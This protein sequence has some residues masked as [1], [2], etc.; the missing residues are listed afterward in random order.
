MIHF[1]NNVKIFFPKRIIVWVLL[2][3][4]FEYIQADCGNI[5]T[6]FSPSQTLICGPGATTLNFT[7]ASTGTGAAGAN[8]SWYLNGT[9]FDNTSGLTVPNSSTISA[10]G[11]YNYMLIAFDPSVPCRDTNIVQVIIRPLPNASF[12]FTPNNQCA[13]TTIAFT[14][15]STGTG[16]FT[17][18]TWN[19]G[20][21]TPN[22]T[23]VSPT[24][25]YAAGGSYNV[26]L[27]ISNGA[28][29]TSSFN[30]TVTVLPRPVASISGD[31]GDGDTQYCLSPVDTTSIETV[32]F[33][34]FTTGAVSYSWN[35]GDGSPVFNTVSTASI[36]HTYSNY[37]TYTV[38]MTATGA[39]GC[40]TTTT[41]TVV[42]DKFV[43]ASFSV[44]L[45]QFSGCAPHVVQPV[46]AS[47]NADQYVWNFGDGTPS[48]TTTSYTPPP[49][50]YTVGGSY[51]ISVVASNS[52][53]SSTSTVGPI[54]VVGAP[55][56][57]FTATPALGC[58][59][60]TVT[61]GNTTTGASPVNNYY[62]DFGNGNTLNGVRFP[63]PQVYYQGT[64]TIMM[65]AGNACGT[66]T[67]FRTIVVDTIPTAMIAV[68]PLEGC[69]PL[70]VTTTNNSTGGNLT[71]QWYID[72]ILTYTTQNIPNQTFTAPAGNS[73]VN[74]TI[75]LRVS[76]H[77]GFDDTTVAVI[78]HPLVVA[79][80]TP[81]S[82]TICAGSSVTFT[83]S[84]LGD[85]LTY[86]W[87]FGNGN[88]STS[89]TA[90]AQTYT[91]P[92]TYTVLLTVT[93]YC[94]TDTASAIV[95]VN[96]IPV[97]PTAPG[98]IICAG[99]TVTLNA[100]APGGT[101]QWYNAP[102]GGTL[103]QT[104]SSY[105]TPVLTTTTSY[106]VQTTA[107]GCT[108]PRTIVTV[109]VNP[110]PVAPTALGTTICAGSTATLTATAPGGTY[111]WYN[112][113]SGGTLLNTGA[114]YTTPPLLT[115]TTYYVQT[116][117]AGCAGPRTAVTVTVNP[118]PASPTVAPGVICAG[119]STTLTATAPGGT[120]QWY[121]SLSGGTLLNTGSSFT[122]PVL[123]SSTTYYVQTTVAG[124][125]SPRV[126]VNV[127]VNPY[128]VADIIPDVNAGCQGLVVNFNNN[129]TLGGS[130][131]WTFSGATPSSSVLYSPPPVTFNASGNNMVYLVVTVA[132]CTTNDTAYINIAPLPLPAF[133]LSP[134]A[135]CSPVTSTFTNTSGITAGDTYF[136]NFGNGSTS[137]L[138]NPPSMTYTATV[139]DSIYNVQL[140]IT[141]ANG[142]SDSVMH[143]VTVHANPVASFSPNNDTVCANTGIVF[144][145]NS[146]GATSYSWNFGDGGVSTTTNTSHTYP[147]PSNYIVQLIASSAFG[148]VDTTQHLVVVD[149][150]P[151][152]SFTNTTECLGFA[153]QF[154]NTSQGSIVSW[155]WNFGDGS[156]LDNSINPSHAYA[157]NGTYTVTLTVINA[158]G[159]S[160]TISHNVIVNAVPVAAFSSNTACFGQ[161]TNFTDLTSGTPISWE[162][163]F[164][165]GSPVNNLQN[166]SHTYASAG[167]YTVTLISF[168]GS[169]CSDTLS[170]TITV[171]P[172]PSA[173][174]SSANVCTNDTMI[175]SSTSVG[176]PDMFVWN[177][178]DGFFDNTNN[179]SS[180]HVYTLAGTYNVVLTVGYVST[181][182]TNSITIPVTSY[183]LT[184]PSFTSTT[185]CLNVNTIFTDATSNA[186]TQWTWNFGDGSPFDNTQN[187]SHVYSA[188][189]TYQVTLVTQNMFGCRDSITTNTVVNPLPLAQF[190]F[191]TVC[192]N[193]A[194]TY[195]DQSISAVAWSW[196]FGDGATSTNNSPTHV[197]ASNGTYNVSLIVSNLF[198]CTDTI[199]HSI[200]VNP[201]PVSDFT[202]TTACHTYPTVFTDNSTAA[203]AWVWD[204]G[205]ASG[206]DT[207]QFP[208]YTYTNPG[209]YNVSL[210]VT[211]IFGCTNTSSQT[212][213]VLPQPVADFNYSIA[214][215]RQAVNFTDVTTVSVPVSWSW[216]FGDGSP[217]DN[218]QNPSHTY[219]LGGTYNVT[220]IVSNVAGCNDTIVQSVIVNTV[221]TP[222]FSANV[223]CQGTIT[224]FNDLS[225][226]VVAITNWYYDFADGNSSFSQNPN[227]IYAAA[228]TYNVSLTVTNVNGCDSTVVMPV[229]VNVFPTA[230]YMVD[231]VCVG[232]PTTFTDTSTGSPNQWTWNFGDGNSGSTG[233]SITHV[234]A[235]AGSY[236]TSLTVSSGAGC[237]D[238]AFQIVVVR[239]DVQAGITANN[240]IC[241]DNILTLSDNS[242]V[243][244]GTILSQT[245]DF[246][247]GTPVS[248]A[249]NTTHLYPTPGTY[250]IT[251]VVV[252]DGGCSS[253]AYD[254][255]V[256]NP[257]PV[258]NFSANNT[259]EDQ[260][261]LFNDLSSGS[262]TSWNWDFG[263]GGTDT[264]QNPAY[265]YG[266][267]G[268]FNATLIVT[269][270]A[271]CADTAMRPVT[272]YS[273]PIASFT[274]NLVCW[275]DTTSFVNTSVSADGT[276]TNA[277]WDFGDGTVSSVYDPEHVL[278]GQT[279]T[280]NVTLAVIT[281]Y[282]CV[283]TLV[284]VVNTHPL[285]VFNFAPQQTSGCE[286]FTTTFTDNSTVAGGT[287]VNWLWDFG[288]GNLTYTQNPTHTYDEDGS[289]FVSLTVTSSYGC[290]MSDTLNFPVVVY[291]TPVAEFTS[292][293]NNVSVYEPNIQF[294][295]ASTGATMWDW[296]FGDNETSILQ[297][298]YHTYPDTGIYMVTLVAINQYG[299]KDTVQHPMEV[300][301][302]W[303]VFI[304]NAFTPNS[305][306]LNDVFAPKLYGIIEYKM[307]IFDRWGNEIFQTQDMDEGWNGRYKGVGAIVQQDVYVYKIVV[308]DLLFNEHQYIGSVT[309]VR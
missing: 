295:D 21:G 82:S 155:S 187:P 265:T 208:S 16:A 294:N 243:T 101:Y 112:A 190:T 131:S 140:L 214:C 284:Q 267:N 94:G 128:P 307:Y 273:Q 250:V 70:T 57:N 204:F 264:L 205:D 172:V 285:P 29:C 203:V 177:F 298:P 218:T 4:S 129:S 254:T 142:C 95:V 174:F 241:E 188:A 98:T 124:C 102:T 51:T 12:T 211:N 210:L 271:G 13:G 304:P 255:V 20:D 115:T 119:G 308:K 196:D 292:S 52:C 171:N 224:S 201:N 64:W 226:D 223:S 97:A 149:S 56:P 87:N 161:A 3:F 242:V 251:H 34:N 110:A 167:T 88:T 262:I 68:N 73:P 86:S 170:N 35:F 150:V 222:L 143:M 48:I 166:P 286:E 78:V 246:G 272:I 43:S 305:N 76:N 231:T 91:T 240:T 127:T 8:Y 77:C 81:V 37:G 179:D 233:P 17:T 61:F 270:T 225:S 168:G 136:W 239:S 289:Y 138:Q 30:T 263:D 186:P 75:R 280:Y 6:S 281:N 123:S 106:Y 60:Q 116:T 32:T 256:V 288:D 62:W 274:S 185:P 132:G 10:V 249:L 105:T 63:P 287:I 85:Q 252:S 269:T 147:I 47:Q 165:D 209:N 22:S 253:T 69:T 9:L 39:N 197:Y 153:T 121:D 120:Y 245:W 125:T 193:S 160:N 141:A 216:D 169:G 228:G 215:A 258:A 277:W 114:S 200:I 111:E 202:A 36:P 59:P 80:V 23:T 173:N 300:H 41:L 217:L 157:S 261:S 290:T 33:Y 134:A 206:M 50:T 122:T 103:L 247:D 159:C 71:Y 163:D 244:V 278:A 276:I 58:S 268:V 135:G 191:D 212:I 117:V 72:G 293:S 236:L 195:I 2:L 199:S 11:T 1:I 133:S 151:V 14:N 282:G 93:G 194:T 309:V 109:T 229:T 279:D 130:Y 184:V 84:S 15:T 118:I 28:G 260:A 303:S 156:P 5:V 207:I 164:G 89:A 235:T 237:T 227:Y 180:S 296:D 96:P 79:I 137:T 31:D 259:C 45:A 213:T 189:G 100:T 181:G 18:Y 44:P 182:C 248:T 198:G 54:T 144:S 232:T 38:T 178:G 266:N 99:N 283:D 192:A 53:N 27:T 221:P 49:H 90:P 24:H 257:L 66:D 162:W 152:A 301:G 145:N 83:Q 158:F 42:F 302:E 230:S 113:A 306:G 238:Q 46:N 139:V 219:A 92:G 148:C 275:G 26:V 55:I 65:V 67:M 146:T 183:P 176:N 297:N 220:L 104:G 126:A 154:T 7:N 107:L 40:T 234:Y 291:P 108:S 25:V 74:H 175:F 299:C 19:W